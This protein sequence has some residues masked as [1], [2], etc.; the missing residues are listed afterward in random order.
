MIN[1]TREVMP[2]GSQ[3]WNCYGNR[4]NVFLLV[5]Y[6]FCIQDN[7]YNSA[8]IHMRL[9]VDYKDINYPPLMSMISTQVLE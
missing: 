9:D 5:T 4:T 1:D 3:A 8:K 7:L 2:K 6:G